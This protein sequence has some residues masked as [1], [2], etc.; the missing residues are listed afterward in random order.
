MRIAPDELSYICPEAW[1]DIYDSKVRPEMTRDPRFFQDAGGKGQSLLTV[2]HDHH[3][4]MRKKLA[5]GFTAKSL[6]DMEP[7]RLSYVDLFIQRLSENAGHSG[8][9]LD[10]VRWYTVCLVTFSFI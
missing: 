1:N 6:R 7:L 10:L 2:T 8:G 4:A 9:V 5:Q 3:R